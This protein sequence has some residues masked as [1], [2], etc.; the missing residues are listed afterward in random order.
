[1]AVTTEFNYAVPYLSGGKVV[2]WELGMTYT[3]GT[4]GGA[5]FY[6]SQFTTDIK[7]SWITGLS[8]DFT[9]KAE[10]AWTRADLETLMS[11][12]TGLWD[13]VF[14]SQVESVIT[15]PPVNPTPDN[16]YVIPDES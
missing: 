16:S 14:T 12:A 7:S 3:N 5:T 4:S 1:M 10:G 8:S 6:Q 9:P 11:P 13:Q 15:N 2:E